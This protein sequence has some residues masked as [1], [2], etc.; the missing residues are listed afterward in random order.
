M[1]SDQGDTSNSSS[2]NECGKVI[3]SRSFVESSNRLCLKVP[4]SSPVHDV[5]T[6]ATKNKQR[7]DTEKKV[8]NLMSNDWYEIFCSA[9]VQ[10]IVIKFVESD[11]KSDAE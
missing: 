7:T 9:Q 3:E 2:E 8:N 6:A 4:P 11:G 10:E 1:C 5:G